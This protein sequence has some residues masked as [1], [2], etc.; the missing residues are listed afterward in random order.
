MG[1]V[2]EHSGKKKVVGERGEGIVNRG[3]ESV[4]LGGGSY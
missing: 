3:I 2:R 1:V 4:G